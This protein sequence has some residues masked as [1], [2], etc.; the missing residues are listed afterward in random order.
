MPIRTP[1]TAIVLLFLVTAF[2][3]CSSLITSTFVKPTAGNLRKQTDPELVC[4]GAPAFLLLVDSMIAGSPDSEDLLQTG[5]QSYSAYAATLPECGASEK[6]IATI[7]E[8]AHGYGIK[9][10]NHFL[11]MDR[12]DGAEFDQALAGLD[13]DDVPAV[14]WGTF[15]WISWVQSQH[16]SPAA[17]ADLVIIEKIMARLLELDETFEAGSIHLFFAG[18]YAAKPALFGG[19]PKQSRYHFKRALE[20]SKRKFLPVQATYAA[21]LARQTGDR[22]LYDALLREILDFPIDSAPE[23]ALSNVL[24]VRKARRLLE[25]DYFAE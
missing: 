21:T 4:E 23:Y 10:L 5:A 2:S 24:A 19:K 8:K 14:F 13:R 18:Y 9:L 3:S 22:K 1:L 15:G 16:G 20:I 7:T 12:P 11:P 25:E 17:M 6:R